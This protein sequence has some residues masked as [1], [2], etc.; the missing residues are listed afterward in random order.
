MKRQMIAD[1]PVGVFLSG[2]VDS[3][4]IAKLAAA[5]G[6]KDLHTL[7]IHF[8]EEKYSE[9]KYQDILARRLNSTHHSFLLQEQDFHKHFSAI[10]G[11][12]DMPSCDGINTWFISKFAAAEGLKA[13]LSGIGADELFG[14]YPSFSRMKAA[15]ALQRLPDAVLQN[16]ANARLKK[17]SRLAYLKIEG[18]RGLYLFLRGHFTPAQIAAQLGGYEKDIWNVLETMPA[19]PS[20]VNIEAGNIAGSMEF[21]LYM[22]D[23]LLR[24]ADVM[25]MAHGLE[26][27]VPFLD[28]EVIRPVF[29][30]S[31]KIKFN[32]KIP[33][34]ILIKAFADE[35]PDEI[36]KRKK[37]GF[38][39]P[40]AE[41][42]RNSEYFANLAQSKNPETRRACLDF[43]NG[44]LH[45]SRIMSLIV[46]HS[47]GL[48]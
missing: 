18:I 29:S 7:S 28:N 35:L 19:S 36:W 48:V 31:E 23:Q 33:K 16:A 47:R 12:M 43:M 45:W 4:I 2:G 25:S 9:K 46:L 13:V 6:R 22:Q 15:L 11:A 21:N 26:I 37:M 30:M 24:D 3:G 8:S 20:P 27:R 17:L 10:L 42:L 40:F 39:F 14:G 44:K 5:P 41:W 34:E 32:N 1:A 38:S